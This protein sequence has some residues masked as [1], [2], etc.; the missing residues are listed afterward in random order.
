MNTND[1]MLSQGLHLQLN[2]EI[3]NKGFSILDIMFRENGWHM[4]KNEMDRITY[5]KLGLETELFDIKIN[6]KSISVSVPV[7]NSPFQFVTSFP[8]Y[9]QASEYVEARFFD[10]IKKN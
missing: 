2:S 6:K 1:N 7:L 5:T 3:V 9:F 8:D 4:I 10:F